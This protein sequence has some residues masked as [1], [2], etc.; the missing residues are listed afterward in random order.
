MGGDQ[1]ATKT[2]TELAIEGRLATPSD[3]DCD[4]SRRA[5]NLDLNPP[6]KPPES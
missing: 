3:P 4:D 6:R 5:R 2:L 1:M